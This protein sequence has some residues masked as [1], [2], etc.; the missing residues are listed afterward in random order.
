MDCCHWHE[1]C[2][3]LL[4]VVFHRTTSLPILSSSV[5][6]PQHLCDFSVVVVCMFMAISM[7]FFVFSAL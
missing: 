6:G 4:G 2:V 7:A 5:V 1:F 3:V